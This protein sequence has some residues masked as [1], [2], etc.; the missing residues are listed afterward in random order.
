ML[1]SLF[2]L[3]IPVLLIMSMSIGCSASYTQVG[4]STPPPEKKV[5]QPVIDVIPLICST[6]DFEKVTW[7]TD[8]SEA[9]QIA[10]ALA[11]NITGSFEGNSGWTN[12]SNNF[13][14]QGFSMGILNQNLGQG[15]VQPLL[16]EMRDNHLSVLQS[17]MGASML[18]SMLKM[19]SDW[20][21]SIASSGEVEFL[22]VRDNFFEERAL[23]SFSQENVDKFYSSRDVLPISNSKSVAWAKKTIYSDS[24]AIS[25][26]PEWKSALKE[27][28]GNPAYVSLQIKA[29][30]YIHE[31][32]QSYR[33][34]LGWS[35]LRSYLYLFDI[36][37][38]NGSLKDKHF[39]A[40][41]KWLVEQNRVTEEEQMLE[42]LEIRVKDVINK[43]QND[44]LS[45]KKTVI[46]GTGFVHGEDR[47]LPIEYCYDPVINY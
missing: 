40:F 20:E 44:V 38:Q 10:F 26:K 2:K 24:K 4:D 1:A 3:K 13:D 23:V 39:A 14:G 8:Y 47:N 21:A 16:I 33:A 12:L 43:W 45:R 35:Q 41:E 46:L 30:R 31:R 6:L 15:T 37:V 34:R 29:A 11:M 5:Q 18:T 25:F 17:V 7:P 22:K 36:V 9:D 32:A 28:A 27:L 19:L 42:M